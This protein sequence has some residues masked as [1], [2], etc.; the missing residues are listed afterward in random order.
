MNRRVVSM[1]AAALVL[2]SASSAAAQDARRLGFS[3]GGGSVSASNSAGGVFHNVGATLSGMASV[4]IGPRLDVRAEVLWSVL[5]GAALGVPRQLIENPCPP[6]ALCFAQSVSEPVE[7]DVGIAGI[8]AS[9]VLRLP[10]IRGSQPYV[11]GSTGAHRYYTVPHTADGWRAGPVLTTGVLTAGYGMRFGARRR[12][13]VEL[14]AQH[15]SA[16]LARWLF[17]AVATLTL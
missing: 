6:N 11:L 15:F 13:G 9:L 5:P 8:G 4:A 12:Y 1:C 17:P 16:G 10:V 7:G 14:R 3:L 2:G